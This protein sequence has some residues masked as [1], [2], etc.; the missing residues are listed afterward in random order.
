M[1]QFSKHLC[2]SVCSVIITH[3]FSVVNQLLL[4]HREIAFLVDELLDLQDCCRPRDLKDPFAEVL[5]PDC[6]QQQPDTCKES[7]M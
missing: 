6:H 4:T 7:I 2:F 1:K 5:M 3:H